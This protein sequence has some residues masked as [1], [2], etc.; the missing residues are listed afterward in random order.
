MSGLMSVGGSM[1][2]ETITAIIWDVT[3]ENATIRLDYYRN[4]TLVDS[5]YLTP[6]DVI[7]KEFSFHFVSVSYSDL[8]WH[9]NNKAKIVF[10]AGITDPYYGIKRY[11]DSL[12][13][14]TYDAYYSQHAFTAFLL[15]T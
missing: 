6:G 4:E 3:A 9:I 15:T 8:I 11:G 13:D 14:A 10:N 12:Y 2:K 7:N 1:F 5:K